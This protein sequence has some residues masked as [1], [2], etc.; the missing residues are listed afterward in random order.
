[1]GFELQTAE[2]ASIAIKA[3]KKTGAPVTVNLEELL[4]Q[5]PAKR[6]EWFSKQTDQKLTGAAERDLK[7]AT[8]VDE[9]MAALDRRIA[10]N[11]TAD[12]VPQGALIF[13]PS[14]ERR[15]SGSHYTPRSLTSPIVKATL[16][17]VLKQLGENPKPEQILALKVCDPAMGSGAF[18]VE[19]CRQLGD[20]LV[21]A[22]HTHK[23]VPPLPPDEDELLHARRLV[24]Q[25][26]LYGVDKNAMAVD[27]AKLSLWLATLARD[28]EFTF[29]N[30]SLRHGD[31]LLGLSGRQ[32]A[33]FHWEPGPSQT[34]FEG[35]LR[36]KIVKATV[37]RREI[38]EARDDANYEA[39]SFKLARADDQLEYL[40]VHGD[41]VL[42]A[43]FAG[44]NKAKRKAELER[45]MALRASGE[46]GEFKRITE[47][48]RL[49]EKPLAS[50][51][52]L[53]LMVSRDTK[54][55][56]CDVIWGDYKLQG[57]A[58]SSEKPGQNEQ[59][60]RKAC[61]ETV[62]LALAS[63][64]H[65]VPN[66]DGLKL[67]V[68]V[69]PAGDLVTV[70]VFLVN[71]RSPGLDPKP[72]EAYAFQAELRV[73]LNTPA[74]TPFAKRVDARGLL[75]EDWDER[76]ADLQ[77]ADMGEYAVGHNVSAR[78]VMRDGECREVGTC[79]IPEAQVER[80]A[81]ATDIPAEL[82]ME[83][84]AELKDGTEA[85]LKLMGMVKAYRDWI[86]A[87]PVPSSPPGRRTTAEDLLR[88]ARVAADRIEAGIMTLDDAICRL[89]F[90]TANRAMAQAAR[91]RRPADVPKWR[92]FQLA[93]VLMNLQ[94]IAQPGDDDRKIVDLLFFPTGGGKTEAYLGLAA[95]TLVLRR[96]RGQGKVHGGTGVSVLMRYTLRL[97]D[98]YSPVTE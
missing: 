24:A 63:K 83:A 84:L 26:C 74:E 56:A 38:L 89:A 52:G 76:V 49:G 37:F 25:R 85:K 8:T 57:E 3:K 27:L 18:L 39:L 46:E 51:M 70:S 21:E 13:Q 97:C 28:H 54:Q 71:Y 92:P 55:L 69:Q 90:C 94:G 42:S 15:R 96:L 91:R 53:S 61:R 14:A 2:G 33:A 4:R 23:A 60:A 66:S 29:L 82:S 81:P 12:R 62:A 73:T 20:A 1:M 48:M 58:G 88:L 59:W 17:P 11:V 34:F 31:S 80:V 95:F 7:A 87:Q 78:A 75:S 65:K 79:W 22:W 98:S 41:V 30:H 19:A 47:E 35:V 10:K 93:F 45:L 5:A 68:T 72:D 36:E 77:Y 40:R 50:S 9:L 86:A 43:F 6:N 44:N 32:I 16:E 67:A 64:E